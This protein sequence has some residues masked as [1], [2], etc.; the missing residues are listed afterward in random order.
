MHRCVVS[1]MMILALSVSLL[2]SLS[3]AAD[4]PTAASDSNGRRL[5]NHFGKL[6]LTDEQR[7]KIYELQDKHEA[8]IDKLEAELKALKASSLAD[9][10]TVLTAEQKKQL[11]EHRTKATERTRVRRARLRAAA[12]TPAAKESATATPSGK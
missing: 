3:L 8:R 1:S 6:E 12:T 11:A 5:P 7:S 4:E 2:P 9:Y 10:E